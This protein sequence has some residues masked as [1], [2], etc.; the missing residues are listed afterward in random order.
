MWLIFCIS[1][2]FSQPK[3][4]ILVDEGDELWGKQAYNKAKKKWRKAAK[5]TTPSIKAM[6]E[7]RL[8][9]TASNVGLAF[10]GILGDAALN[11]CSLDD[12]WCLLA[13]VD[14]DIMFK[15]LGFPIDL[16]LC[17]QLLQI[18]EQDLPERS[19]SRRAAL[20]LQKP[21]DLHEKTTDAFGKSLLAQG[22]KWD[23]GPG[24]DIWGLS[25]YGGGR[26]GTGVIASYLNPNIDNKLGQLY[27][28]ASIGTQKYGNLSVRYTSHGKI[29]WRTTGDI[30]RVTYFK[31]EDTEWRAQAISSAFVNISPGVHIGSLRVWAGPQLRW[32]QLENPT[33]AHG[34]TSGFRWAPFQKM[35]F[36]QTFE[37][38]QTDYL[39]LR[40]TSQLVG[41]H[42]NGFAA[43]LVADICPSIE[44]PWWRWPTAG[45]DR[46]LRLPFA[47]W[48]R[49]SQVYTTTAEWRMLQQSLIGMVVFTEF[50]Y[51]DQSTYYGAGIG[52]RLRLIPGE[53]NTIRLDVGYGTT[54][55]GL[56]FGLGEFF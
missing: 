7:Y 39:H 47:Q 55:F 6:A 32:D 49:G 9:L 29:W 17:E 8:M 45:G 54:G 18:T 23:R 24:G 51:I 12:P 41:I 42:S 37:F 53:A 5:S 10:H 3:D 27:I 30:R 2:A 36:Q 20:G 48:F 33:S 26:L 22:G 46:Y 34:L 35:S 25:F 56:S 43:Y 40:S 28:L 50:G 16:S 38:G 21:H 11:Q 13:R 15:T 52:T 14:R 1:L 4:S 44:S 19:I 31:R